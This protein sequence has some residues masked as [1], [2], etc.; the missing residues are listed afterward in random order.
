MISIVI[1]A[2]NE[3]KRIRGTLERYGSFFLDKKK[4]KEIDDFEILVVI[5]NTKDRTEG[6]V[7]EFSKKYKEIKYLNFKQGG[8]G[9]A[10][11]EGFKDALKRDSKL[12]GFID[13]D[14]A[15]PPEAFYGLVRNIGKYDGIIADRWHKKSKIVPKQSLFR[16]FISRGYNIITRTL[17]LMPFRD[18]QCGAKLFK[19]EI[20]EKNYKKIITINWNFDIALLYCLRRESDA[21]IK[22]IPTI[23]HDEKGSKVNLKRT[24]VMMFASSVRLRLIHSPF[25]FIVR[26][27]RKLPEKLKVR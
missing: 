10:I 1:P 22:S 16:R 25:K 5:N 15:T 13:A 26:A 4:K 14:M 2:Y 17:F 20:L 23:W 21:R 24:P 19:R 7:K 3:E 9:F 12:I 6:V 27:Y 11:M 8:K 18:T